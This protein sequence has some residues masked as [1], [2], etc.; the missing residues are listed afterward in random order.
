MITE[1]LFDCTD[2]Q[3]NGVPGVNLQPC[4]Q[5]AVVEQ[6]AVYDAAEYVVHKLLNIDKAQVTNL[7][8]L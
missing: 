3:D 7:Q 8:L 2:L 1:T 4:C 6:N 5:L